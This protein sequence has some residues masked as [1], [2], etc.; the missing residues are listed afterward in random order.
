MSNYAFRDKERTEKVYA[1]SLN[2]EDLSTRY[3]CP[4]PFCNA[5]MSLRQGKGQ[6]SKGAYFAA[7]PSFPHIKDPLCS[8]DASGVSFDPDKNDES[9]FDF[10]E[11]MAALIEPASSSKRASTQ[12]DSIRS[13]TGGC[14]FSTVLQLY[15]LCKHFDCSD[16]YNGRKIG[17]MLLDDRSLHMHPNGVFGYRI[18]EGIRL[19][20]GYY[21]DSDSGSIKIEA[22]LNNPRFIFAL[23]FENEKLFKDIKTSLWENKNMIVLAAGNWT[24]DGFH[25]DLKQ[26]RTTINNK[27]QINLIK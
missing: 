25:K 10:E 15:G 27:K 12:R 14:T 21:Y 26:Y 1:A 11:K 23:T 17:Y 9:H 22:P 13:E 20:H 4:N 3:Y 19:R 6:E 7:L 16:T 5:L 8:F 24:Q 18:V 2:K